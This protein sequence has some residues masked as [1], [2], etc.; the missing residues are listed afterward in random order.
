MNIEFEILKD[1]PV[2]QIAKFENQ[3]V[4]NIATLTKDTTKTKQAFP[5]LTGEL[6]R[7]ESTSEPIG[8]NDL[9]YGLVAGVDYAFDVW[10]MKDVNWTNDKTEEQWYHTIFKNNTAIIVQQ[11]CISALRSVK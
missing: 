3:T 5:Y 11:A 7:A 10:K 9:E 6:E 4:K 8:L 1:I 2:Q